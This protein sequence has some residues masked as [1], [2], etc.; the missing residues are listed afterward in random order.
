MGILTRQVRK[1]QFGKTMP[2]DNWIKPSSSLSCL[3]FVMEFLGKW[4]ILSSRTIWF[5]WIC[6]WQHF[7]KSTDVE[8]VEIGIIRECNSI[9]VLLAVAMQCRYLKN[10][11]KAHLSC[12][13]EKIAH[14]ASAQK[15]S[16]EKIDWWTTAWASE[17]IFH[18][19]R[20]QNKS[21]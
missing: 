17:H 10:S 3:L 11:L 20:M 6:W 21:F 13:K 8:D 15:I 4:N 1:G 2:F 18:E 5:D 14:C 7:L 16:E 19:W 9:V 12:S